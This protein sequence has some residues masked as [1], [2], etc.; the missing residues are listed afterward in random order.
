MM[1]L[2][3]AIPLISEVGFVLCTYCD[4]LQVYRR[5]WFFA[6]LLLALH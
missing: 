6:L 5:H 4:S 2:E 1:W 3:I